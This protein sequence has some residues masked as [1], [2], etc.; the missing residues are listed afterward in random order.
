V[1]ITPSETLSAV[2]T[3][4]VTG[5]SITTAGAASNANYVYTVTPSDADE[6]MTVVVAVGDA[7]DSAGNTNTAAS[8]NFGWTH[9]GTVPTV[10]SIAVT[11]VTSGQYGTA[12][13]YQV[14]VTGSEQ[15]DAA[16]T[17]TLAGGSITTAGAGSGAGSATIWTYTFTPTDADEAVTIDIAAGGITDAAGND[18]TA[19]ATQ[20][21]FTHDR[22]DPTATLTSTHVNTGGSHNGAVTLTLTF[23]EEMTG[24]ADGDITVGGAACTL[25]AYTVATANTVFTQVCGGSGYT[26]GQLITI[27]VAADAGT[28]PAGN[29]NTAATDFT[30]TYD[31]TVPTVTSIAVTGV[32]SGQYG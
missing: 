24:I 9:D 28:D 1:T 5:G 6:A 12:A 31:T 17:L 15:L 14:I 3:L 25:S 30:W 27:S 4:T 23:S 19:A 21:A 10:T 29:G 11:G 18:N 26:N 20:F 2:P 22:T 8:N 7:A 32:T 16:P 13:T